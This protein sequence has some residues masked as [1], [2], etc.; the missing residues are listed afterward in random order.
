M[1][2]GNISNI[3]IKSIVTAVPLKKDS[4]SDYPYFSNEEKIQ[5]E[6]KIGII[7][8]RNSEGLLTTSDLC[9]S[10][11]LKLLELTRWKKEDIDIL[12]F[13]SQTGDYILPPTSLI[14]QHRLGLNSNTYLLDLN[15]GCTGWINGLIT[16]ASIMK[17]MN[18]KKGL[19]LCGETNI[20]SDFKDKSTYPLMGDA[21]TATAL[22]Y[23]NVSNEILFEYKNFGFLYNSIISPNSKA[24]Y[25]SDIKKD[26]SKDKKLSLQTTMNG[27][28]VFNFTIEQ[29]VP[30]LKK[31][32]NKLAESNFQID[33]VIFHQ[34][35]KMIIETLRKKLGIEPNRCLNSIS[36][37]GNTSSASI[38]LTIC[39]NNQNGELLNKSL[40][41]V[42]FGVGMSIANMYYKISENL[43]T[44]II[45]VS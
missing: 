19:L 7:E 34:A 26:L 45:E 41:C 32:F 2:E 23:Q 17:S 22:E 35:N 5:F 30:S 16:I 14:L 29:V 28:E 18:F 6:N 44:E 27:V 15:L 24:R 11:T 43:L 31:F 38:P 20:L 10:A 37:F 1:S 12:I 4:T 21:G 9:F 40:L 39:L 8:K 13:V 33:Y 36:H 3:R 42:S 25:F